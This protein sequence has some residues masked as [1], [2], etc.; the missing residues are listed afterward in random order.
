MTT[1][2]KDGQSV[3]DTVTFTAAAPMIRPSA[4]SRVHRTT[5]ADA[6]AR[7]AG[8]S[9][10]ETGAVAGSSSGAE[11]ASQDTGAVCSGT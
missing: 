5:D 9:E 10:S 3:G 2:S 11:D 6:G 7:N 4:D 8:S 1:S